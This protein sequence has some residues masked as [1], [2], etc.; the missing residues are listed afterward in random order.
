ML[1]KHFA[2]DCKPQTKAKTNSLNMVA[3]GGGLMDAWGSK[4]EGNQCTLPHPSLCKG[5]VALAPSILN[6]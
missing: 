5:I 2:G 3:E 4:D 6:T 1:T